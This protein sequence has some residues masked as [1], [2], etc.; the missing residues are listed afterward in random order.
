[1]FIRTFLAVCALMIFSISILGCK[2]KVNDPEPEPERK[3]VELQIVSGLTVD[4]DGN[5]VVPV[6]APPSTL[7]YYRRTGLPILAP[8]GHQITAGEFIT[9]KGTAEATCLDSGTE[10]K[11]SMSGLIPNALYRVWILIFK[12]PGFDIG[13][14]PDFSNM[15][16]EG[17][18]GPNDRSDNSFIASASGEGSITKIHPAGAMSETL[19]IPPFANEPAG[20]C[21][22]TD[23]Y[24]WHVVVAF[25]QPNQPSGKDVGPPALFPESAVEQF[26][27]MFRQ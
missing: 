26:V 4:A 14:P 25:Q 20:K 2:D 18:L 13:P 3:Q 7:L 11:L 5:T 10:V 15:I 16:G 12:K 9:A 17:A 21:L 27:F 23:A 24:E 8:D 6:A 1:M 22:L 19:P